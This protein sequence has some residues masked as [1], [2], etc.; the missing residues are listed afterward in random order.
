MQISSLISM[1]CCLYMAL[2]ASPHSAVKDP[3]I[4]TL[5][6]QSHTLNSPL[7]RLYSVVQR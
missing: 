6:P 5:P 4:S 2:E 1:V 7:H 3:S